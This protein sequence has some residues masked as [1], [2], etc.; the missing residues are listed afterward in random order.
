MAALFM[1]CSKGKVCLSQNNK[2][3][4]EMKAII[5]KCIGNQS[6]WQSNVE[7]ER[8]CFY[9]WMQQSIERLHEIIQ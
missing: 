4:V 3:G 8:L 7:S 5:K 6:D 9:E 1:G 2:N